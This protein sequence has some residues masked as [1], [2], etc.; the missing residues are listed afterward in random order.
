MS[1]AQKAIFLDRDGVIN[2]DPG[3]YTKGLEEFTILPTVMASLQILQEAGYLLIIITNQGGI[4]KGLYSH[5]DVA[6]IHAFFESECVQNGVHITD[7]FYSPHHPDFGESLSRKPRSL[8]IERACAKHGID[9]AKSWMVGD[10]PR[11][12]EAGK[13]A[14]V[15]GILLPVNGDLMEIVEALIC[16][17]QETTHRV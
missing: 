1:Q 2:H 17:P 8:M 7:I 10:K 15:S 14:G 11:D 13:G 4:A 9:P 3:D 5:E 16:P 6:A 12:L